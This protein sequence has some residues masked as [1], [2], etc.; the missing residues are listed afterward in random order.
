VC[1]YNIDNM[2]YCPWQLG[3]AVPSAAI[4]ALTPIY[5]YASQNCNPMSKGIGFCKALMTKYPELD[6]INLKAINFINDVKDI[7]PLIANNAPCVKTAILK[8]YYGFSASS[9]GMI[10]AIFTVLAML[11]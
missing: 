4:A 9:F 11:F 6:A 10:G 1:G 3:D 5:A 8:T 2:F 7:G